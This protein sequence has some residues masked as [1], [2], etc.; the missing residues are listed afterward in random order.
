MKKQP[1]L[2]KKFIIYIKK[3]LM[4]IIYR[5]GMDDSVSGSYLCVEMTFNG[6]IILYLKKITG[7]FVSG[8]KVITLCSKNIYL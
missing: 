1:Q 5:V 3:R 8:C 4:N 2:K 6:C 7:I